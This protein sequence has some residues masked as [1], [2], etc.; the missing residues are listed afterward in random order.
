MT[1]S[2]LFI[3]IDK[4]AREQSEK[5][6]QPAPYYYNIAVEKAEMLAKEVGADVV[7]C[8]IGAILMDIKLGECMANKCVPLHIQKGCEFIEPILDE[9]G[10]DKKIKQVLLDC[11]K[12]HHGT[13]DEVYPN[14]ESEVVAN[15]DC[16]RFLTHAGTYGNI[17]FADSLGFDQNQNV[18]FCLNK[19]EEKFS[20]LS[21]EKAKS[22][23]TE[24]YENIKEF[25]NKCK[26]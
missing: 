24:N 3:A 16:Y 20:V 11:I 15:A 19:L 25:L 1:S 6:G 14:I 2:E 18:E 10:V 17:L 5:F 22:D 26:I 7:L 9:L 8:K 21:I 12:F 13:K 4:I 23:L